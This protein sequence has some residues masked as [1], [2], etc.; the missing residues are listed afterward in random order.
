MIRTGS[1]IFEERLFGEEERVEANETAY[2]CVSDTHISGKIIGAASDS[3]YKRTF[4]RKVY[5]KV[6]FHQR[7]SNTVNTVVVRSKVGAE[8]IV[9]THCYFYGNLHGGISQIKVGS[10][11]EGRGIYDSKKRLMLRELSCDSVILTTQLERADIMVWL[12]PFAMLLL[13]MIFHGMHGSAINNVEIKN[14]I[15]KF[16]VFFAGG[17]L[18]IMKIIGRQLRFR[19]P[20]GKKIKIC[21][22]ASIVISTF[23]TTIF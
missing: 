12:L 19:V 11:V 15:I 2:D 9:D 5:D 23:L 20:F 1:S 13:I 14:T 10:M 7:M 22:I 17:F 6:R 16:F 18:V 3:C 21:G 4:I 8:N